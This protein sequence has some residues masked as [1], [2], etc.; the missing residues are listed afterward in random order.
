MATSE[1]PMPPL[2]LANR[3]CSL[4]G[5]GDPYA[6]YER[7]GAET[8]AAILDLLPE[9][10]SFQGKRVLDFG[11]GAGRTL[12]HFLREATEAEVWGSDIDAD[13]IAWLEDHLSPPLHI[14]RNGAEP[15]LGLE[16]GTLDLICRSRC[17]RT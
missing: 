15:P 7:L 9:D 17:S 11:C 12:R 6:A 8:R 10:W 4:D 16:H 5:R 14:T 2:S 3:V 13:S 1:H